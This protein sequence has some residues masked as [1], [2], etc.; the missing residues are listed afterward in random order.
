VLAATL[1]LNILQMIRD[2]RYENIYVNNHH[3]Q[4]HFDQKK[5]KIDK[6]SSLASTGKF[7]ISPKNQTFL[8]GGNLPDKIGLSYAYP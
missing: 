1:G 5:E 4:D 3:F 2:D 8:F 7:H 6:S